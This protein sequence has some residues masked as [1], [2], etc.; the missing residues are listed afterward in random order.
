MWYTGDEG[1]WAAANLLTGKTSPAGRL[2]FSWPKRL[3]DGPATNPAHLEA[4]S[5]GRGGSTRYEEGIH[6]GYRWFDRERIE[7]LFPFGHGLSYSSF[8]YSQLSATRAADG[9]LDVACT[10]RNSGSREADEV[11]QVYLDAPETPP[12]GV[13]FDVRALADFARITLRPGESQRVQLHVPPDRLR[14]WSI[15]DSAWRAPS[16]ARTVRVGASSRDL[17]LSLRLPG[18]SRDGAGR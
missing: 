4:S 13:E 11:V 1:G 10:I 17:R 16:G 6:V 3:E 12:A 7:P 9:G 18:E 8:Q 15:A 14:Y 2:P 5:A